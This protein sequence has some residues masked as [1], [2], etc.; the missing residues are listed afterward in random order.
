MLRYKQIGQFLF[1]DTFFATSKAGK[2]S[3]GNTCCQIFISDKS[4][5]FD[6]PIKIK[7][8]VPLS[9]NLFAKEIGAPDAIICDATGDQK[10]KEVQK[11]C[12]QIGTTLR[13]LEEST[14]W[15]NISELYIGIIKESI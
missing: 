4:F 5:V 6:V 11:F 12:H 8:G 7:S 1:M 14:P 10:S 3:I 15:A 13:Y 2:L 9:L